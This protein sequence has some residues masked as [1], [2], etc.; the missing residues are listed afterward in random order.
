M[1]KPDPGAIGQQLMKAG[2]VPEG[3]SVEELRL[4]PVNA[5]IAACGL[6]LNDQM[7]LAAARE[8]ARTA[9]K[10]ELAGGPDPITDGRPTYMRVVAWMCH[11]GRNR[12]GDAFVRQELPAAAAKIDVR[13]PLVM[14]WNHA[15]ILGGPGRVI[16]FWYK[17]DYAFDQKAA[18]G[19]GRWGILVEG[20]MF[21]WA[22]PEIAD[23]MLAE[24]A[25]S[26]SIDFSMAC[27]PSSV[28]FG[29][30]D[31]KHA[32]ILH[33]PVFFTHSALDVPPGDPDAVGLAKE[34]KDGVDH[35]S[36]E[37]DLRHQLTSA[38]AHTQ[39]KAMKIK[40]TVVANEAGDKLT[41]RAEGVD[42]Q[43]NVVAAETLEGVALTKLE[44]KIAEL[45]AKLNEAGTEKTELET[46]LAASKS[47]S[48]EVEAMVEG[49]KKELDLKAEKIAELEGKVAEFEAEKQ[50]LAK[51]EKLAARKAELPESYL[52]EHEKLDAE[53]KAEVE[54]RWADMSDELWAEK[55]DDINKAVPAS[56]R[57][58]SYLERSKKEGLIPAHRD[59]N[60]PAS[61]ADRVAR[62]LG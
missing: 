9:G 34:D 42:E 25:R 55:V 33:N 58:A 62:V 37:G 7:A 3:Y 53:K 50:K 24:Q 44:E 22:Y 20:L 30:V 48:E 47:G 59:D 18:E 61:I 54:A 5:K 21:A 11:E 28:E 14:D 56:A 51:A 6:D 16:G 49:L 52:A 8:A 1:T 36:A 15:A 23:A 19:E 43:G 12:N 46:K 4:I 2:V 13:H 39:E 17:A 26:G 45:T 10:Q 40:L 31:G 35:T 27:I 41:I 38:S 60:K 32:A 29:E 57:T